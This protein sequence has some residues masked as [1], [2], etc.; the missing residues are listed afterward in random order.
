MNVKDRPVNIGLGRL[1]IWIIAV[2]ILIVVDIL[3]YYY[4]SIGPEVFTGILIAVVTVAP[5]IYQGFVAVPILSIEVPR[6]EI[7]EYGAGEGK[8]DVEEDNR[9]PVL[10]IPSMLTIAM[11]P[12]SLKPVFVTIPAPCTCQ[13]QPQAQQM[14]IQQEIGYLRLRVKNRGLVAAEDCV[15]QVKIIEWPC[16]EGCHAPS[17]EYYDWLDV[18]WADLEKSITIRPNDVRYAITAIMPLDVNKSACLPVRWHGVDRCG[19]K[20]IIAWIARREVFESGCRPQDGLV[21]GEYKI[22]VQVTCKN[23]KSGQKLLKLRIADNWHDT[24]IY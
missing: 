9:K 20:K 19:C 1:I 16:P 11:S 8:K 4:K 6:S 13:D 23:G 3:L 10:A 14:P 24:D 21:P 15:F 17:N 2:I 5:F 12:S 7:Q 22:N 18:T